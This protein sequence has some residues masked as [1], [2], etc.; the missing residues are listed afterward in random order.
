MASSSGAGAGLGIA[1]SPRHLSSDRQAPRAAHQTHAW[2]LR[3]PHSQSDMRGSAFGRSSPLSPHRGKPLING[4]SHKYSQLADS[5]ENNNALPDRYEA[6]GPSA[7]KPFVPSP[8]GFN[9]FTSSPTRYPHEARPHVASLASDPGPIPSSRATSRPVSMDFMRSMSSGQV[10]RSHFS[11]P[12]PPEQS[13]GLL[14]LAKKKTT[15]QVPVVSQH[16][17]YF[18]NGDMSMYAPMVG[19]NTPGA[20]FSI[21]TAG[22]AVFPPRATG[23]RGRALSEGTAQLHRQG[24]LLTPMASAKRSSAELGIILGSGSNMKA[25]KSKLLPQGDLPIEEKLA[26]LDQVKLEAKKGSKARVEVDVIL[27]RDVLVE[28][29]DLRGRLEVRVRRAKPGEG[30]VWIGGG[31]MR[32]VGFEGGC[33]C[34]SFVPAQLT[35]RFALQM[36]RKLADGI[37]STTTPTSCRCLLHTG[38]QRSNTA[39]SL[40]QRRTRRGTALQSRAR[41]AYPFRSGYPREEV[42]KVHGP[43][44]ARLL[45]FDMWLLGE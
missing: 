43:A 30:K 20:D 28:G 27:E 22:S 37:S 7:M 40:G 17:R 36:F 14:K 4:S 34:A 38:R 15:S 18:S 24:T 35:P 5:E 25:S 9:P 33:S 1:M 26:K 21:R 29:G 45:P 3:R 8:S 39:H 23:R 10:R 11:P 16:Q 32:I 42:Q 19:A 41:T 31:K 6:A 13:N 12:T 2:G 44:T